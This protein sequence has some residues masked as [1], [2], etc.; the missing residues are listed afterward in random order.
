MNAPFT[1]AA[2]PTKPATVNGDL[3]KLPSA[4]EPFFDRRAWVLWRWELRDGKWTKPP[5]QAN[6][7]N[8]A[9]DKPQ[10]WCS[11]AEALAAYQRGGFD[12]IG[13]MTPA[14]PEITALD[15]DRCRDPVTGTATPWADEIIAAANSYA[16][17][18]PSGTGFRIIG[19]GDR[20]NIQRKF[21]QLP[22]GCQLEVFANTN[23]YVTVTGLHVADTWPH[24]ADIS[25]ITQRLI[26]GKGL[27]DPVQTALEPAPP[28]EPKPGGVVHSLLGITQ[29]SNLLHLIGTNRP[30][31]YR[32][33]QFHH[34]VG[35]AKRIG[36]TPERLEK[37]MRAH[38]SGI[39]AKFLSPKDRLSTEIGRS[40]GKVDGPQEAGTATDEASKPPSEAPVALW[41][42]WA[43][44]Y[45]PTFPMDVLPEAVARYVEARG[46][47]T[48]A[49]RSGIAMACLATASGALTHEATLYLKPGHNFAVS[50]RLW[51]VLV[52]NPSAKKSPAIDGALRPLLKQQKAIQAAQWER[53]K[54]EQE[55]EQE[56]AG[57]DLTHLVL[58]DL[59]PEALCDVL[60]R[61][62][63]GVLVSADELAGWMGAHDRYGAGKGAA[64]ARGIWLQAYNGGPYNLLRIG[65]KTTP[66]E[67]LSA[68]IVGG[69]QPDRL[70]QLGD[71]TS[72]GLLQRFLPV[73][74]AKPV[75]DSNRFD[76]GAWR[77]WEEQVRAL[78]GFGRFIT[79]LSQEAQTERERIAEVLFTLGQGES[80][81]PAWQGFVGKLA[82]VWGAL[83][84]LLHAMWGCRAADRVDGITAGRASRLIEEFV[85]P[86]GLC[87]YRHL[88]GSAQ[89]ENRA[90]AGFLAGWEGSQIAVRDFVRG[91]RC[92]RALTPE[93]INQRLQP[94][95]AGGWLEPS[96]PGPW[97]RQWAVT[98]R[99]GGRFAAQLAR[100]RAAVAAIQSKI[101]GGSTDDA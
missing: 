8:A 59:T 92:C 62:P 97:N 86:H 5:K 99:L 53:W 78:L 27:L 50:A 45:A 39:A 63:R 10:T 54:L 29:E 26:A 93:E 2:T 12:G 51:V 80:E 32:H 89:T 35:W 42:P 36:W 71:L 79:E 96:K 101:S 48:G 6:G 82:G 28:Y 88:V 65:R 9:S 40:W 68:S 13:L 69:I 3:S 20:Q 73:W 31:G 100:H 23:R 7:K 72:D 55:S 66:V 17:T 94:F 74:M 70:R 81:G 11:Y 41:D 91:P 22:G 15:L 47:E 21:T 37:E 90:I 77:G 24:F 67:N 85:L 34:A 16:E 61:Q 98:P 38:P 56:K 19:T 60:S 46:I 1:S 49:C 64:S 52:G 95:E 33:Q 18:T 76:Q 75:L 30:D 43:E 58:N 87:F 84:L 57:P 25:A 44:P 14:C 83:A 4:F